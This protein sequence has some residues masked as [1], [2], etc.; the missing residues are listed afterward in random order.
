MKIISAAVCALLFA[1]TSSAGTSSAWTI[2]LRW[3]PSDRGAWHHSACGTHK[4]PSISPI[5]EQGQCQ[6]VTPIPNRLGGQST[7]TKP[8]SFIMWDPVRHL[9]P[10]WKLTVFESEKCVKGPSPKKGKKP[11]NRWAVIAPWAYKQMA[12]SNTFPV[13]AYMVT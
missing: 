8:P 1:G 11:K 2:Y 10:T 13:R 9:S 7:K 3:C 5:A 12:K 6:R 4:I